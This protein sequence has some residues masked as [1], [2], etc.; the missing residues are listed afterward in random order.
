MNNVRD[1]S[2]CRV[3]RYGTKLNEGDFYLYLLFFMLR[4][5][6]RLSVWF[7]KKEEKK[8]RYKII[9]F[10]KLLHYLTVSF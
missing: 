3:E 5:G 7:L 6:G 10:F 9:I 8:S 1:E 2:G 4:R